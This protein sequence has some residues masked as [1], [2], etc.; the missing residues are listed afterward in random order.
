MRLIDN[1]NQGRGEDQLFNIA[2]NIFE[3]V[4]YYGVSRESVFCVQKFS[5]Q[6]H[7][8]YIY[9]YVIVVFRLNHA[10]Q[11]RLEQVRRWNETEENVPYTPNDSSDKKK[12]VQFQDSVTLLEAAARDD[13]NEGDDMIKV[14]V[15]RNVLL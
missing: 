14:D 2:K 4:G 15:N 3:N 5:Y 6:Y 9:I 7:V 1:L 11:R 10:K 13:F 8:I 12:A